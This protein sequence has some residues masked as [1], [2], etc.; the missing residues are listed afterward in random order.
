MKKEE[1]EE[2]YSEEEGKT[3]ENLGEK[4]YHAFSLFHKEKEEENEEEIEDEKEDGKDKDMLLL[5]KMYCFQQ[6]AFPV[7]VE[8]VGSTFVVMISP[9]MEF[10]DLVEMVQTKIGLS[11]KTFF[12]SFLGRV[13]DSVRMKGLTRD[14]SVR[15]NFRLRGGMMR[16]PRDSPGQWTSD[17][18]GINRCWATRSTCY[19]FGEARGHTED[20]QRH[21]RNMAREAREKGMS[22]A[23]TAVGSSSTPPPWAATKAPPPRSVPPRA[24]STAPWAAPKSLS[25]VDKVHDSDQTALLR[26]A[27][28]LFDDEIRK[29][30][31]PHRPP[32]RKAPK[33]SREQIVL[34]MKKKLE[35]EEQELRERKTALD[36][37][38]RLVTER[39]QKVMDQ[40]TIVSDLKMQLVE[41]RQNIANNPTPEVSEDEDIDATL[42]GVPVAPPPAIPPAVPPENT[43]LD[44]G[45]DMDD[46]LLEEANPPATKRKG[47]FGVIQVPT[48]RQEFQQWTAGLDRESVRE[49][50]LHFQALH[51]Q[52]EREEHARQ[53]EAMERASASGTAADGENPSG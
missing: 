8:G 3:E 32:T 38:R 40:A 39:E 15:V 51:E 34:N 4:R 14:S 50:L 33:V 47:E 49:G 18:C 9:R 13:L 36:Q 2:E 25:E 19:R 16:V 45:D 31:P 43:P 12:L 27:L 28:E 26:Q 17:C 20:L 42:L 30:V 10:E 5:S 21:Y 1:E 29:V 22:G 24:S 7:F 44:A 37:A 48:N 52:H 53:A 23:S 46:D 11:S 35:K 41:L 6:K